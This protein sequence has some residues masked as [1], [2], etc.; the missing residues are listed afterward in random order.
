MSY[1]ILHPWHLYL[2]N[3]EED[4]VV[5][6]GLKVFSFGN[7]HIVSCNRNAQVNFAEQPQLKYLKL[8]TLIIIHTWLDKA[9]N[10]TIVNL[11][12]PILH[13]GLFCT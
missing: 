9:F 7:F 12:M 2:I 6:L 8:K 11:E 4:I 13:R 3:N 10:G 5:F 1:S